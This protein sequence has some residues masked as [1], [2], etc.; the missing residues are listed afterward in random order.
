MEMISLE[1][2]K[3][4]LM[5]KRGLWRHIGLWAWEQMFMSVFRNRRP[6]RLLDDITMVVRS[7]TSILD[8]PRQALS[9][10]N[11]LRGHPSKR[12]L[13]QRHASRGGGASPAVLAKL[14]PC[15]FL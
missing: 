4:S 5:G 10:E 2:G 8:E 3:I 15:C 11:S 1:K 12:H 6:T 7:M 13:V 9:G 14:Y